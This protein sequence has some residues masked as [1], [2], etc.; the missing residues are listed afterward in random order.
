MLG[1][2]VSCVTQDLPRRCQTNTYPGLSG[3]EELDHGLN[4]RITM[5]T[6]RLVGDTPFSLGAAMESLR[7]FNDGRLH[8]LVDNEGWTWPFVKFESF[9]PEQKARLAVGYGYT[10]KY[11]LRL[12]HL[13]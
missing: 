12:K 7:Q 11:S 4:G 1:D 10:R 5:I 9:E 6:G 3:I 8:T 13:L 2:I